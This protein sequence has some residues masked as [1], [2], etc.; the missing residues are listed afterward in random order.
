MWQLSVNRK[1][2]KRRR[3]CKGGVGR[4]LGQGAGSV[5]VGLD[6]ER[7]DDEKEKNLLKLPQSPFTTAVPDIWRMFRNKQQ[8]SALFWSFFCCS[9]VW[10][11][12]KDRVPYIT[13]SIYTTLCFLGFVLFC[14]YYISL[15]SILLQRFNG[16]IAFVFPCKVRTQHSPSWKD[17]CKLNNN[18]HYN[19][20]ECVLLVWIF[21]KMVLIFPKLTPPGDDPFHPVG[22]LTAWCRCAAEGRFVPLQSPVSPSSQFRTLSVPCTW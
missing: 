19:C 9:K 18:K 16:N 1:W 7:Y 14:S 17:V 20:A 4:G 5:T 10:K 22:D 6:V 2:G 15:I 12:C 8:C 21:P 3:K 13:A 11:V